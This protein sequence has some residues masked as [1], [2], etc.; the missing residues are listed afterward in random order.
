MQKNDSDFFL[1]F[2]QELTPLIETLPHQT[3]YHDHLI[4]QDDEL[5]TNFLNSPL[6]MS[7][8][9]SPLP[10]DESAP[11][12][13]QNILAPEPS[14]DA[15]KDFLQQQ[16][17]QAKKNSLPF[18]FA[19]L[20]NN[21]GL[22]IPKNRSNGVVKAQDL[23]SN[24]TRQVAED[25]HCISKEKA[26]VR[27]LPQPQM[28]GVATVNRNESER[29]FLAQC[30]VERI[31]QSVLSAP[32]RK[33]TF[34]EHL[35]SA[36][37]DDIPVESARKRGRKPKQL[38]EIHLEPMD[39]DILLPELISLRKDVAGFTA[40]LPEIFFS[41]IN[42]LLECAKF[43]AKAVVTEEKIDRVAEQFVQSAENLKTL[44]AYQFMALF[45]NQNTAKK[46][47]MQATTF[48][49]NP[50]LQ[51]ISFLIASTFS[52]AS[53]LEKITFD[54]GEYRFPINGGGSEQITFQERLI[55][56]FSVLSQAAHVS[57]SSTTILSVACIGTLFPQLFRHVFKT[58]ISNNSGIDLLFQIAEKNCLHLLSFYVTGCLETKTVGFVEIAE[59]L[60]TRLQELSLLSDFLANNQANARIQRQLLVHFF[61]FDESKLEFYIERNTAL[62][63]S[64]ILDV[65]E[66]LI[67]ERTAEKHRLFLK[68]I[69]DESFCRLV[70]RVGETFDASAARDAFLQIQA[71]VVDDFQAVYNAM[72][73][74]EPM[75][76][77]PTAFYDK[78]NL[79]LQLPMILKRTDSSIFW[80]LSQPIN[81]TAELIQMTTSPAQLLT[82]QIKDLNIGDFEIYA[83]LLGERKH[84][85]PNWHKL[86]TFNCKSLTEIRFFD[87]NQSFASSNFSVTK[88]NYIEPRDF[89]RKIDARAPQNINQY[90]QVRHDS[91]LSTEA[92]IVQFIDVEFLK[93]IVARAFEAPST[94]TVDDFVN[95]YCRERNNI[96]TKEN[97]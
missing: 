53:K 24:T 67:G 68:S 1:G 31:E 27:Q 76:D 96:I 29:N 89:A 32:K 65:A 36:E 94:V 55:W 91:I 83:S 43:A 78:S 44:T 20:R 59:R 9:T 15:A 58:L 3:I 18:S 77:G 80:I 12:Q 93:A 13:R 17:Q 51:T 63:N 62:S 73:N 56:F 10:V 95:N 5:S 57:H 85:K 2:D 7:F 81:G 46:V 23:C 25:V 28:H 66:L 50:P 87:C 75:I 16:Q 70:C 69:T 42:V 33:R 40:R 71:Y 4:F 45:F 64:V 26:K 21:S 54:G 52:R 41:D 92:S 97:Y 72:M 74:D 88:I 86:A 30:D 19:S 14:S 38:K 35:Q 84:A 22:F 61:R 11:A 60:C 90:V 49:T 39:L 48:V 47:E 6:D 37:R 79:Y 34:D 8:F 82:V